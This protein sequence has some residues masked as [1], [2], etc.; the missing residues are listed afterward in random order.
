MTASSNSWNF[1]M[2]LWSYR[3]AL[4]DMDIK[5]SRLHHTVRVQQMCTTQALGP[6]L[7]HAGTGRHGPVYAHHGEEDP[8]QRQQQQHQD[9]RSTWSP[10]QH[11]WGQQELLVRPLG[12]HCGSGKDAG[13]QADMWSPMS[14]PSAWTPRTGCSLNGACCKRAEQERDLSPWDEV[15]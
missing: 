11:S 5:L 10:V 7:R 12:E 3:R 2:R 13:L 9:S 1:A 14:R 4:P 15:N 6:G 8:A